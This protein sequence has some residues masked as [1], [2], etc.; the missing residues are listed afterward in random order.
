MRLSSLGSEP[1]V[2]E[3]GIVDEVNLNVDDSGGAQSPAGKRDGGKRRDDSDGS[4]KSSVSSKNS[5]S[6]RSGSQRRRGR[7]ATKKVDYDGKEGGSVDSGGHSSISDLSDRSES[8]ST[9]VSLSVVHEMKDEIAQIM[10]ERL[11]EQ[12]REAAEGSGSTKVSRRLY[13]ANGTSHV[14]DNAGG[15]SAGREVAGDAAAAALAQ[16][17]QAAGVGSADAVTTPVGTASA[18]GDGGGASNVEG[19]DGPTADTAPDDG[20][21]AAGGNGLAER[22]GSYRPNGSSRIS[23]SPSEMQEKIVASVVAALDQKQQQMRAEVEAKMVV[24]LGAPSHGGGDGQATSAHREAVMRGIEGSAVRR[25]DMTEGSST[26]SSPNNSPVRSRD[27]ARVG[28]S[29]WTEPPANALTDQAQSGAALTTELK[30]GG[31]V[32]SS[33]L[34]HESAGSRSRRSSLGHQSAG[35][36]SRRKRKKSSGEPR[37]TGKMPDLGAKQKP[38]VAAGAQGSS[39]VSSQDVTTSSNLREAWSGVGIDQFWASLNS[40]AVVPARACLEGVPM[41]T[42]VSSNILH[43]GVGSDLHGGI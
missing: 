34:G 3:S 7:K 19:I 38:E 6:R 4:V 13:D 22:T 23:M 25:L 32:G 43:S 27:R 29:S 30:T 42:P 17:L 18:A 40:S 11:E 5:R 26:G 36:R 1:S 24:L 35:S 37:Q 28:A 16:A 10:E 15:T 2:G 12:A 20:V 14:I 21:G 41:V 31:S 8:T 9:K 33:S 39:V